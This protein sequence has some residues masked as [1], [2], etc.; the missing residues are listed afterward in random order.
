MCVY[1]AETKTRREHGRRRRL[2][3]APEGDAARLSLSAVRIDTE[4]RAYAAAGATHDQARVVTAEQAAAAGA[5]YVIVGRAVTQAAD[6]AVAYS[7][8]SAELTRD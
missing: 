8:L 3:A 1:S 5:A 7:V 6:P 4:A 2:P